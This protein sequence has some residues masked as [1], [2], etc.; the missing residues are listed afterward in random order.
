MNRI[1]LS[2]IAWTALWGAL[3]LFAPDSFRRPPEDP[4]QAD[5]GQ[6]AS[7]G[8]KPEPKIHLKEAA[9]TEEGALKC[10]NCGL[11]NPPTAERCDCGYDFVSK[12][13]EEPYF[14]EPIDP[15]LRTFGGWLLLFW[16]G[17]TVATPSIT[18]VEFLVHPDVAGAV[19][20][21]A[22]SPFCIFAG[23]ALRRLQPKALKLVQV[24]LVAC[25]IT[26]GLAFAV[27]LAR[28][29]TPG[30]PLETPSPWAVIAPIIWWFYFKKSKRVRAAFGRNL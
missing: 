5:A 26:G 2:L 30:N 25:F 11:I 24:Y 4:K 20:F 16:Y 29:L 27:W 17:M 12:T 18:L 1:V 19:A 15:R 13:I 23:V 10:P 28:P 22:F 8:P 7:A 14:K 3:S 6:T 21:L 9:R